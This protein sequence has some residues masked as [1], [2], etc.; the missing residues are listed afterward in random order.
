MSCLQGNLFL[1]DRLERL[2][3]WEDGNMM[4]SHPGM[5]W[6]LA[7]GSILTR[8]KQF[9]DINVT[10]LQVHPELLLHWRWVANTALC[11]PLPLAFNSQIRNCLLN[12]NTIVNYHPKIFIRI[13]WPK[14]SKQGHGWCGL[15]DWV[16]ACELKGC[17]FNSQSGHMP[18]FLARSHPGACEIQ[19]TD[20]SF[21]HQCFSPSLSPS[22]ALSLKINTIFLKNPSR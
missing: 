19:P 6:P 20:A 10:N 9:T 22:F 12:P 15:V 5:R 18:G 4:K 3:K 17:W 8:I 1:P 13:A 21:T 7:D 14:K 11:L 2:R 16:A